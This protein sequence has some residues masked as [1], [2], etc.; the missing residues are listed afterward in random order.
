MKEFTLTT[1]FPVPA[2]TVYKAWLNSEEHAAMTGG[3]ATIE[4]TEGSKFTAWDGYI[5]GTL[6]KLV[7]GK[8]I[9]QTWKTS[10]FGEEEKDSVLSVRL[11]DTEEG[12]ELELHHSHI[13][14]ES[15]DYYN[16]WQASYF[17]PML[18]YF[19]DTAERER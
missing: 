2:L 8:E 18:A 10:D 16:G 3:A 5:W 11:N 12:C 4:P 7:E 1:N 14:D 19:S 13:P 9:T 17:E 15:A 6:T